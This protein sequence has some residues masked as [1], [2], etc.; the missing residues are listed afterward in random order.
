[1]IR[2]CSITVNRVLFGAA[3]TLADEQ[4]QFIYVR[5]PTYM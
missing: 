3:F 4:H 5:L 2:M 1:M